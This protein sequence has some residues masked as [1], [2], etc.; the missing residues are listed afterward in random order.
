ML[1]ACLAA[2]RK[3]KGLDAID[4]A[5]LKALKHYPNTKDMLTIFKVISFAPFDPVSKKVT[6]V[7][8]SPRGERIVCVKGELAS[9]FKMVQEAND[10]PEAVQK[11]Y[12]E[13]VAEFARRGFRSL[14]VARKRAKAPWELLGITPYLDPSRHDT[15]KT[16]KEAVML[17][18]KNQNVDQRRCRHRQRDIP[19]TWP[20][21]EQ[22]RLGKAWTHWRRRHAG[23]QY[24]RVC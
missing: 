22:I 1:V 20:W 21:S 10:I 13:T 9:I 24:I 18:L 2:S 23:I 5:F 3:K 8:E 16:V 14:G 11:E 12:N 15:A 7:V 4:K 19:T 6:A 17:G